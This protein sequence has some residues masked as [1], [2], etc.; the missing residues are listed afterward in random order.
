MTFFKSL[1]LEAEVTT[2]F[3]SVLEDGH[4]LEHHHRTNSNTHAIAGKSQLR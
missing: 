2:L 3:E 4:S 1:G